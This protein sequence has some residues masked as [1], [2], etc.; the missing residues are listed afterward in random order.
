MLAHLFAQSMRIYPNRPAI[1]I[2]S[3]IQSYAELAIDSGKIC[4]CLKT[5]APAYSNICILATS[6]SFTG[7]SGIL[8][9]LAAGTTY[10]PISPTMPTNRVKSIV[11]ITSPAVVIADRASFHLVELISRNTTRP[12][13][14]VLPEHEAYEVD[15]Q[16]LTSHKICVKSHIQQLSSEFE[17]VNVSPSSLA[18]ILFTSGTTGEPK[19]VAIRQESVIQYIHAIA[20]LYPL[21]PTD[22]CTQMFELTFDL[23]V[24]DMFVTWYAGASLFVP[25]R[26]RALFAAD[27]VARYELTVWFSVP[28]VISELV[29]SKK[30]VPNAL[31]SLRLAFFCGERFPIQLAKAMKTAAPNALIVNTYGPTEATIAFTHYAWDGTD[32]PEQFQDIPIGHP[33]PEQRV[34]LLDSYRH[35]VRLGS[36]GEIYLAGLQVSTGYWNNRHYSKIPHSSS[37]HRT[38]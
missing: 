22:R 10:V 2:D 31:Q 38:I 6:R 24:H 18:Y 27:T 30:L 19:G 36:V 33:L 11:A 35:P 32:L 5:F 37:N 14:I 34:F 17:P 21:H 16:G 29:R 3:E 4:T 8:G 25:H 15:F 13:L 9:T 7:F 12:L 20:S 28:S 1:C 23:S 26:G